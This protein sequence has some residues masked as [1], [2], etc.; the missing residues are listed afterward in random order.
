MGVMT[1]RAD[2]D[3][4]VSGQTVCTIFA[5]AAKKWGDLPALRWKRD[6]EWKSL[7]WKG[8]RGEVAAV[9]MAL[10]ELGFGPGQFGLIMARNVPEHV[11]ADLGI[12][13]DGQTLSA[14]SA[15]QAPPVLPKASRTRTAPSSGRSSPRGVSSSCATR[16]RS[17]TC[18]CPTW[19]SASRRNGAAPTAATGSTCA[20]VRPSFCL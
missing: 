18:R 13:H 16:H 4:A 14:S 12:V 6:G 19:R 3:A 9:T 5:T 20:P 10:K 15:R 7:D 1:D 8:Y 11:I 17:A 2:I